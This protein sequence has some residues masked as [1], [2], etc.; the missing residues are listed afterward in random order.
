ML[1]KTSE[2]A[3]DHSHYLQ[4]EARKFK[5][6]NVSCEVSASTPG[7]MNFI[8]KDSVQAIASSTPFLNTKNDGHLVPL[9]C[10]NI[11][12]Y[13]TAS[14]DLNSSPSRNSQKAEGRATTLECMPC[15]EDNCDVKLITDDGCLLAKKSL[16]IESSDYF[17]A[18]FTLNMAEKRQTEICLKEIDSLYLWRYLNF[19]RFGNASVTDW[20]DALDFLR[21]A[22]YLQCPSL[23][24]TC[25]NYLTLNLKP[26]NASS[27]LIVA[28]ELALDE[29]IQK[30]LDYVHEHFIELDHADA[31][32]E[33]LLAEDLILLLQSEGLGG[34]SNST[35]ELSILKIVLRWLLCNHT[36]TET[37][38]ES[39]ISNV[40]FALIKPDV[41]NAACEAV[42]QELDVDENN[43]VTASCT[44]QFGP[45]FQMHLNNAMM[46]HRDV[47]KQPLMQ[48][49][50]TTL[51]SSNRTL[52]SIDGVLAPSA[53]K[54]SSD[55]QQKV[56]NSQVHIRDPFHSVVEL[57]GF[58]FILGGTR[59]VDGG[60]R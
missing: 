11:L 28:H 31:K 48:T 60:F 13:S 2:N 39:I 58:L 52:V 40:R 18:M 25:C 20:E 6:R 44:E 55:S 23:I 29:L 24:K 42:L 21:L 34:K 17:R 12:S 4:E 9:Q 38:Q 8:T 37:E 59:D 41:I 54:L 22:V 35:C 51:R 5:K 57:N 14:L 32:V 26:L 27:V 47:Y 45:I 50:K 33:F 15:H 46:Y 10:D 19:I 56:D 49:Q 3:L 7:Y 1:K 30:V 53:I 16:L 36:A 43:N